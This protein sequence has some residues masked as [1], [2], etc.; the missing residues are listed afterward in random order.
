MN[1]N[2]VPFINQ[3]NKLFSNSTVR[4]MTSSQVGENLILSSL[5]K[6]GPLTPGQI[7]EKCHLSSAHTAKTILSLIHI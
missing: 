7:C 3:L 5:N 6:N 1:E 2:V 4:A